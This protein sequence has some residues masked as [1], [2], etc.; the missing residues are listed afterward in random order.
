MRLPGAHTTAERQSISAPVWHRLPFGRGGLPGR[1]RSLATCAQVPAGKLVVPARPGMT[2]FPIAEKGPGRDADAA[3]PGNDSGRGKNKDYTGSR[4]SG[5]ST[6]K[7]SGQ[8]AASSD[9]GRAV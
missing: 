2:G 8:G 1:H 4:A 5:V 7:P 6:W 3:A 9:R